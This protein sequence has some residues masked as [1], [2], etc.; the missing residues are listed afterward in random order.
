MTH[1]EKAEREMAAMFAK[2]PLDDAITL[3]LG[4][5]AIAYGDAGLQRFRKECC[6]HAEDDESI[7]EHMR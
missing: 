6:R 2:I 7:A 5:V 4:G 3:V 1:L